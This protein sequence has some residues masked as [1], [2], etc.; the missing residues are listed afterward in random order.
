MILVYV[1]IGI[2]IIVN[3]TPLLAG[4]CKSDKRL[5]NNIVSSKFHIDGD[6]D[7]SIKGGTYIHKNPWWCNII[8]PYTVNELGSVPRWYSACRYIR[9]TWKAHY[10]VEGNPKEDRKWLTAFGNQAVR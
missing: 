7:L 10:T 8:F 9:K 4:L 1:G 5:C 2:L 3:L 6:G